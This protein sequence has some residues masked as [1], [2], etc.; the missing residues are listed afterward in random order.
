MTEK[1]HRSKA[2]IVSLN[3][4]PGHVSHLV[5]SYRQMEE[6]GYDAIMYVEK[7]FADFMPE[8]IKIV[9]S[10]QQVPQCAVAFILFPSLHNLPLISRLRRLGAR[11]CYIFHEPMKN[12]KHYRKAGVPYKSLAKLWVINRVN[13]MTIKRCHTILLPSHK[14]ERYYAA[15]PAYNNRNTMYLPLMFDDESTSYIDMKRQYISYIGT[16]AADHSFNEFLDFVSDAVSDDRLPQC[17]FL[18]ATKSKFELPERLAGSHRVKVMKGRPL[19]NDEINRAYASSL[20]IWNAYARTTQSG[21]LAK[22]YMFGTPAIVLEQNLNEF[23]INHS[24][25]EAVTD[26]KNTEMV[27]ER[28]K[29]IVNDFDRYS[30]SCRHF[31]L[32]NFYY[33]RYNEA[34]RCAL[35]TNVNRG[36]GNMA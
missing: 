24:T 25:V 18:I 27:M 26:N 5:A 21:V 16:V 2:L 3:F 15:N 20:V 23:M 10:T 14:A 33:R 22:A 4:N 11:I 35:L 12:L 17:K 6:L 1:I 30:A 28:V 31:F 8:G 13:I 9:T 19:T 32:E 7:T 29:R 34:I 36:G